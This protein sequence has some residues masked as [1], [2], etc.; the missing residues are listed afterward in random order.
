MSKLWRFAIEDTQRSLTSP[1]FQTDFSPL[2]SINLGTRIPN[3]GIY[4]PQMAK[5]SE[6]TI[7][8]AG[9][10]GQVDE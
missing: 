6:R 2:N 7:P 9:Q 4:V 3:T 8:L 1:T 10:G 5:T